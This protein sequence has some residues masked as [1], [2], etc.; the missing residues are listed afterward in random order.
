MELFDRPSFERLS[1]LAFF[2]PAGESSAI[3]LGNIELLKLDFGLKTRD[4]LLSLR[5]DLQLRKRK[6]LG[7]VPVY[8]IQGNQFP[9][10]TIPLLILGERANDYSQAAS[11]SQIF[12]FTATPGRG[13]RLPQVA[14]SITSVAVGT[15]IKVL[16]YDYFVDDPALDPQDP[17]SHNGWI[18]LPGRGGTIV[19]GDTV[20]VN[21]S[22]FP[23]TLEEYTAFSL[24][25][26]D[27]TLEVQCEDEY[28]PPA[29][30]TWIM[31][32]TLYCKSAPDT[33]TD[34]FRSYNLEAAVYGKP[35]VRKR[36]NPYAYQEIITDSGAV[37]D[38]SP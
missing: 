4:Y 7:R 19:A 23:L 25:S 12:T 6:V 38:L 32:V 14:V 34:K 22:V 37:L 36:P 13:V 10:E 9:T 3:P 29:R 11:S 17:L 18:I 24:T 2:T 31:S 33:H 26:R 35:T 16:G 8:S 15:D 21:Y 20:Q 28:G 27:G 1:G 30:E 5:G